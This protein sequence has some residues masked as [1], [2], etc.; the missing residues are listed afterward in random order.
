[1][2]YFLRQMYKPIPGGGGTNSQESWPLLL[3]ERAGKQWW[4]PTFDSRILE[5]QYIT[6]LMPRNTRR[7]QIGKQTF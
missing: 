6:S 1:M 4:K 5:Q 3:F 7:F 2:L